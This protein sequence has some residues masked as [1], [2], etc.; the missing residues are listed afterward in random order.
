MSWARSEVSVSMLIAKLFKMGLGESSVQI[1]FVAPP[2]TVE[3]NLKS[4][5]QST[6]RLIRDAKNEI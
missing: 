5:L 6:P 4:R 3:S 1:S 2:S